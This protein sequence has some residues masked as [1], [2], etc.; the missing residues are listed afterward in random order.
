MSRWFFL[1]LN[2]EVIYP[3]LR[4]V[5]GAV[6]ALVGDVVLVSRPCWL[7]VTREGILGR[8]AALALRHHHL[9]YPKSGPIEIVVELRSRNVDP[10]RGG[11]LPHLPELLSQDLLLRTCFI[12]YCLD[13]TLQFNRLPRV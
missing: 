11:A 2:D 6:V 8:A 12:H 1:C 7:H 10:L 13:F 4:L 9:S 3:D 5:D